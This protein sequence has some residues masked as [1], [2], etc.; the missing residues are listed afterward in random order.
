M[1]SCKD[2]NKFSESLCASAKLHF[3]SGKNTMQTWRAKTSAYFLV[4]TS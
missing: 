1:Q 4:Y 2:K 3:K